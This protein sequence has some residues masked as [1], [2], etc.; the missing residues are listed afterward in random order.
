MPG[1][2]GQFIKPMGFL[3]LAGQGF[4]LFQ[5][6]GKNLTQG[7]PHPWLVLLLTIL[8][9]LLVSFKNSWKRSNS[10]FWSSVLLIS[11]TALMAVSLKTLS[12]DGNAGGPATANIEDQIQARRNLEKQWLN[13]E[14]A[15]PELIAS[16]VAAL[17]ESRDLSNGGDLF[18]TLNDL[19]EHW[20]SGVSGTGALKV[21][22]VLWRDGQRSAW[23]RGAEPL[24]LYSDQLDA[25]ILEKGRHHWF[26]RVT[27]TVGSG[28]TLELQIPLRP[29]SKAGYQWQVI[30]L[31]EAPLRMVDDADAVPDVLFQDPINRLALTLD[32]DP[33][34]ASGNDQRQYHARIMLGAGLAW[35]LALLAVGRMWLGFSGFLLAFWCG[36]LLLAAAGFFR[37]GTWA[38]PQETLPAAPGRLIS[39]LDP[40]YFATPFAFGLLAS[41]ADALLSAVMIAVTV[42]ALLRWLALVGDSD[43]NPLWKPSQGPASG[44]VF[45]VLAFGTLALSRFLASLI[46]T[47]ANP[48]LIGQDVPLPFLSFWVL[49]LVLMLLVFSL[50]SL[51]VGLWAG[52]AWPTRRR[53]GSWLSAGALAFAASLVMA[54][55]ITDLWWGAR[56]VLALTVLGL[57]LIIPSLGSHPRFLRRFVWPVVLLMVSIWNYASLSEVYQKAEHNWLVTKA[58]LLV[59]ASDTSAPYLLNEAL[60]EMRIQDGLGELPVSGNQDIWRDEPAYLLWRDSS[61]R[62]LGFPL[63]VEIIDEFDREESLFTTGF[64]GDFQYQVAW[65]GGVDESRLPSAD[66]LAS[67]LFEEEQRLYP[68]GDERILACEVSREGS[69]GWLRVE[70]PVRST[71]IATQLA[72][73]VP[74]EKSNMGGYRPRSEVDHPVL[75][76]R[77]DNLGWLDVGQRGIPGP[78][79]RAAVEQLKAG[80]LPWARIKVGDETYL[81]LW[82][83]QSEGQDKGYL[84]GVQ[85][86][87]LAEKL[88]DLSRLMLLNLLIFA[89]LALLLHLWRKLEALVPATGA[90]R[91]DSS[92]STGFQERFLAGYLFFGLLLL[93][94]VGASVDRV[95]HERVRAEARTQTRSGLDTAVQQLRGLLDE[96]ARAFSRSDY[97]NDMLVGQLSG[98]RPV[99]PL[100]ARQAMVFGS[101]GTLILDETLSDLSAEEARIL[102]AAG[103]TS[104]MVVMQEETGLFVATIIPID[105]SGVLAISDTT[106]FRDGRIRN[107]FFLYRQR[108]DRKL[109]G[110]LAAL[111][112]GQATLRLNGVPVLASHPEDIFSGRE[113]LLTDSEMM[114]ILLDHAQAPG[115]FATEKR[116]FAYT[117][118]MPLPAFIRGTEGGFHHLASPAVFTLA[119]PDREKEFGDQ[120]RETM[121]FLAGLANLVLLTALL[122]ALLM[123]WN[124]FRPL[125]LLLTATRSMARGDFAAPLP[126]AGRDEVGRLTSAFR[127]MRTDLA[128]ARD[129]LQ[130]REKFLTS[131]LDRVTVGVAVIDE[132]QEVVSLNPS[133]SHILTDFD[134]S[135]QENEGVLRLLERF[136][137]LAQGRQRWGGEMNSADGMRTLRGAMAPLDLP[138]GRTDTM[139]VFED[140]TEFL[141]TRKM[142]INAELARQ[143]AHEIKNPLTPIQLSVQLLQQAWQDDHPQLDKIVPDT[144]K[145]VLTQVD[146]L[147]S[148]AAEFSLL[149]RP[150]ELQLAALDLHALVSQTVDRYGTR[151]PGSILMVNMEQQEIP[152]VMA[153]EDSLQKIL[154]NLMQNSLDATAENEQTVLDISWRIE[155]ESVTLLWADNGMGLTPEVADRLFD[156]YFSTKSKGTGLGLAICRN[157]ADRMGGSIILRNRPDGTADNPGALAELKLPRLEVGNGEGN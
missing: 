43:G 26:R 134:P 129:E 151:E 87:S 82:K 157:L 99:G 35:F 108:L 150:G 52:S 19:S 77:G 8:L 121:L 28:L 58:G 118:A 104:P 21:E 40:A 38:F 17:P 62:D 138:D 4:L 116:P 79:S 55:L 119:F 112:H 41:T 101:D 127:V 3:C 49:H 37:W 133:G 94:V 73:L 56:L 33:G 97:I 44:L 95:G 48:R 93:L 125:R 11:I 59:D 122:L 90:E 113:A 24:E 143:V 57:W 100:E 63:L 65:R 153:D 42:W 34:T 105:L 61:L 115:V 71:R 13:V 91:P 20:L 78:E 110:S 117:G 107:G 23:T 96:Q 155:D 22:G 130:A 60:K 111:V 106:V 31:A 5:G 32:A 69:R 9:A 88:L 81:C 74:G 15:F 156:P 89:M 120:R 126:E 154:G 132:K 83:N 14:K 54:W 137:K 45:G 141:Q 27:R 12:L 85:Q 7:M 128:V 148:I 53:L 46:A 136:R 16:V 84:L 70:L 6:G 76:L 152:L 142:A 149:G 147:R 123:S 72:R 50:F 68:D 131:V 75:L 66:G 145:R 10:V 140:I 80:S 86:A 51:L 124:L 47:N 1:R 18:R 30:P 144:V 25:D 98:H 102:L 114:G 67:R 135:V 36:R 139:L 103:R 92:W 2:F 146:L 109:L 29:L 64:M 39:L